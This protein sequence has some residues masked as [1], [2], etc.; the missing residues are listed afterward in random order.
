VGYAWP[1]FFY[2]ERE[3]WTGWPKEKN[4]AINAQSQAPDLM[5][6]PMLVDARPRVSF[7]CSRASHH[8]K[9]VSR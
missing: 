2:L 4:P 8:P 3:G 6:E 1:T 9:G 5:I 7:A